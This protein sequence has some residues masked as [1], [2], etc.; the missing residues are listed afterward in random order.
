MRLVYTDT[1]SNVALGDKVTIDKERF[2]VVFF[3]EPHKAASSGKV[4]VS[5]WGYPEALDMEYFVNVI[6]AEWIERED[7]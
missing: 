2:E 1:G 4:T 6:G 7:R 3:E 5:Q